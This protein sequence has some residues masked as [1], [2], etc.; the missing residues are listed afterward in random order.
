MT[1]EAKHTVAGVVIAGQ[2]LGR[3]I[4][5]PTANLPIDPACEIPDGVYAARVTVDGQTERYAAMANV[6]CNP[7]VGGRERR[8][9]V[10]LFG[11]GGSLYGRRI[12]VAL[13]ERIRPERK[14]P[15]IEAL[16]EAIR[17]DARRIEEL[18]K[19]M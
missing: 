13:L 14:F 7:S 10:H 4:G 17:E 1:A 6:G 3:Q 19:Q 9:E 8:L 11:F 16:G 15:S 5:F 2:Q 12:E 18:L